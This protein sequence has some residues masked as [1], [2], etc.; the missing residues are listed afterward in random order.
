MTKNE[1]WQVP[2]KGKPTPPVADP[3]SAT[4]LP[5]Y[6]DRNPAYAPPTEPP[7]APLPKGKL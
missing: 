1:R 5:D 3:N 6:A 7:P 2:R 4:D